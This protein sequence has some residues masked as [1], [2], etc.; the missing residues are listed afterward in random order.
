MSTH[1]I[2]FHG[3]RWGAS[4]QYHNICFRGEIR[5]ILTWYPLLSRPMYTLLLRNKSNTKIHTLNSKPTFRTCYVICACELYGPCMSSENVSSSMRRFRSFCACAKSHP[6]RCSPSIHS[7]VSNLLADSKGADQCDLGL[8]WR[9]IFTWRGPYNRYR[10]IYNVNSY[11][12][13]ERRKMIIAVQ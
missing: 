3:E 13:D 9:H 7:I 6:G 11:L 12:K 1:N 2:C 10:L 8:C 5:K 4:N